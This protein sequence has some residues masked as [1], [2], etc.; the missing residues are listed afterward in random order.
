[1]FLKIGGWFIMAAGMLKIPG[2]AFA[3]EKEEKQQGI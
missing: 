2:L 1:M 3:Q